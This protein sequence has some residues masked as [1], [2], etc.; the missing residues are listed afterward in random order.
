MWSIQQCYSYCS[1]TIR[2]FISTVYF[3]NAIIFPT[4]G[5]G[6]TCR[7]RNCQNCEGTAQL[8]VNRALCIA[9][10]LRKKIMWNT[11]CSLIQLP[12][13]STISPPLRIVSLDSERHP[14]KVG[15]G[16][17]DKRVTDHLQ[18]FVVCVNGER[19]TVIKLCVEYVSTNKA[20][21]QYIIYYII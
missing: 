18:W 12:P 19:P 1:D 17:R 3:I 6:E 2:S 11:V 15:R 4:E 20:S 5:N 10:L 14:L 21:S 13:L 9:M 7:E 8:I 16:R